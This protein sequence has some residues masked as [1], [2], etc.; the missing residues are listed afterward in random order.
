VTARVQPTLI[1]RD[2]VLASVG[3]AM[4]AIEARGPMSGPTLYYGAGAGALP[5]ASAVVSDLMELARA[6]RLNIAGRVPPLGT[7]RLSRER[8]LP[9]ETETGEY[10]VRVDDRGAADVAPELVAALAHRD[11]RVSALERV[12]GAVVVAT[13]QARRMDIDA[14]LAARAGHIMRI[15]RDLG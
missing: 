10:C 2:G 4:N 9:F 8:L 3:G 7:P 15:E 12:E 13:R 11:V 5:T 6:R 1:P 14:A